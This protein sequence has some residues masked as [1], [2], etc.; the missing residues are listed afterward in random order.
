ME[1]KTSIRQRVEAIKGVVRTW[2]E[3]RSAE[4]S[5]AKLLVVEVDFDTDPNA[6]SYREETIAAIGETYEEVLQEGLHLE[7]DHPVLIAGI[8]IVPARTESCGR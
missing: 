4:R 2:F 6:P 3:W 8:R 5:D 1:N 7:D